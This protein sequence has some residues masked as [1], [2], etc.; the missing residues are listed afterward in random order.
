[1]T[2]S[3]KDLVL[4]VGGP[5]DGRWVERGPYERIEVAG[6][7]DWTGATASEIITHLYTVQPVMLLGWELRVGLHSDL[8]GIERGMATMRAVLQ[9]DVARQIGVLR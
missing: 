6:P 8:R 2:D 7:V 5:A 1:M 9:R 4:L 3:R